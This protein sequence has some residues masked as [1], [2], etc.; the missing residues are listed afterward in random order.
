MESEE[1]EEEGPTDFAWYYYIGMNKLGLSEKRIGRLT[2]GN[3]LRLLRA[4]RDTFDLEMMLV[5]NNIRY[6]DLEKKELTY[7]DVA[8]FL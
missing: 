3:F 6:A 2:R 1:P 5:A 8:D 7:E 4:Y